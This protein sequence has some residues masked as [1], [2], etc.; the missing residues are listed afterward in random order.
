METTR[1]ALVRDWNG[2]IQ[3]IH[4]DGYSSNAKFT[5][6]LRCNEYRVLKVWK[7]YVNDCDASEW[8]RWHRKG[9]RRAAMA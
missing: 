6:D 8:L 5:S 2:E 9:H 4:M 3:L 1:T 7:G